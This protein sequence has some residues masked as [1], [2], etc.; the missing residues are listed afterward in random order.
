MELT[1]VDQY[2]KLIYKYTESSD[3]K[4]TQ[5]KSFIDMYIESSKERGKM[6]GSISE[7]ESKW[8]VLDHIYFIL[9][10]I[11]Y[12]N[13]G[14][15]IWGAFLSTKGYGSKRASTIFVDKKLEDPYSALVELRNEYEEWRKTKITE[16]REKH[17]VVL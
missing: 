8:Q 15:I 9:E 3:E 7:I 14:S 13:I 1:K 16:L 17:G 5:I 10:N 12:E 11:P 2:V 4:I 6:Y